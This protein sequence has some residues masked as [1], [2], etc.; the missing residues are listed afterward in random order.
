MDWNSARRDYL[1]GGMSY[2]QLSEK[3]GM[4]QSAI[5]K[6]AT[7]EGWKEARE[8]AANKSTKKVAD[9]IANERAK[10]D[11]LVFHTA[12]ELLEAVRSSVAALTQSEPLFPRSAKEFAEAVRSCQQAL[13]AKPTEMDIEEQK[14]RI[15]KLRRDTARD[16]ERNAPIEVILQ[17]GVAEY[18][19]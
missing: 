15:E 5:W 12:V 17:G 4:S 13:D 10:A 19:E 14:A 2:R 8:Q 7:K 18:G 3:Y 11:A 9:S 1:A 16:A 6:R